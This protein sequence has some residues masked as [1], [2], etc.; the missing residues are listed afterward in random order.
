MEKTTVNE[1]LDP[2]RGAKWIAKG[3]IKQPLRVSTPPLGGSGNVSP[4][5]TLGDF[6]AGHDSLLEAEHEGIAEG[7]VFL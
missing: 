4:I 3:A 2:P 1:D 6:P 5:E 7:V